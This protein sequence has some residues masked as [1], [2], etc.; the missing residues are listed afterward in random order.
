MG[1]FPVAFQMLNTTFMILISKWI[2]ILFGVFLIGVR[3]LMLFDPKRARST[4]QKAGST[5]LINYGEITIRLIPAIAMI[6]FSDWAKYPMPFKVFGWIM[7]ITSLVLYFVPKEWHQAYS[8]RSAEIL[9]P[10]Y[11]QLI[12]PLSMLLGLAVIYN[13]F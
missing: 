2:I 11:F 5:N 13:A 7:A 3:F 12:S 8:L 9:K 6:I 4:L 1:K 10:M